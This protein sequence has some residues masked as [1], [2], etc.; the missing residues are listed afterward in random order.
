MN[1]RKVLSLVL[2][3]FMGAIV[4]A[5]D[6]KK[7]VLSFTI[8]APDAIEQGTPF[9]ICYRLVA[10][11]WDKWEMIQSD[12]GFVLSDVNYSITTNDAIHTMEIKATAYTSKTGKME[13]PRM[14]IPVDGEMVYADSKHILVTPNSSCGDEMTAAYQWLV[15]QGCHPD[16][17][18]LQVE[19]REQTLTLFTDANHQNFAIVANKQYWPLVGNP[20]LAF[21][22]DNNF[23]IRKNDGRDYADLL[24]PFVEQIQVLSNSPQPQPVP[25]YVCSEQT[26][27]PILADIRWGQHAPYNFLAPSSR[28]NSQKANIGCLPLA[29][30]MVMSVHQWPRTGQSHAYYQLDGNLHQVDF[31]T[32]SPQWEQYKDSYDKTDTVLAGN[33]SLLLVSIG[34]AIDA[35]FNSKATSSSLNRVKQVL[36]NNLCYSGKTT[37]LK[38]PNAQELITILRK[39]L[40][41]GRPCIVASDSHAFV[42]DGYM[43]DFFHFNMGWYG[44]SNGYYRLELGNFAPSTNK[45][46]QWL[47]T[48]IFGIEPNFTPK[49]KDIT[50]K[51]AGTLDNLLTQDEKENT[52]TLRITGPL[53][54]ADILLLRKMAGATDERISNNSWQ[55]G[56]LRFLDLSDATIVTDQNPY[57]TRQ[58]TNTWTHSEKQGQLQ[59]KVTYDF[60]TMT[61]EQ[62]NRFREDIGDNQIGYTYTRTDD[63]RYWVHYQ[64]TDS[65]IGKYMFAGCSSL[66]AI[67][68][69]EQTIKVDDYAFMECSSLQQIRIPSAV[70]ELGAFPFYFCH[71]LE[72]LEIPQHCTADKKGI[73]K[74]C[75]PGLQIVR[76]EQ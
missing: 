63:N 26:V 2:I 17:V 15:A 24:Q 53:N 72:K 18:T 33:L 7:A 22:T 8:E 75:S 48:L 1:Y 60:K 34:K 74:N 44:Q 35:S 58:A 70:Q 27:S 36:C 4:F 12:K 20:I 64:C 65:I 32:V 25:P 61:E 10:T 68:L 76:T 43:Q 54:T 6:N 29:M 55:G 21:S 41:A 73:E 52:T 46:L 59:K 5:Q 50:T 42:C 47:S 67:R 38:E 49:T 37:L 56:A 40:D 11:H 16:S 71:S 69:P 51:E 31:T 28:H 9:S 23:V 3:G 62:W 19:H 39:E 14:V 30:A 45:N 57:Y 13:L 66:N